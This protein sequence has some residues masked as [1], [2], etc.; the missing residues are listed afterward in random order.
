MLSRL[1][2]QDTLTT[3]SQ[4]ILCARLLTSSSNTLNSLGF[5]LGRS[6]QNVSSP[7]LELSISWV[8]LYYKFILGTL[9]VWKKINQKKD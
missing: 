7:L 6:E 4:T 9:K 2:G 5:Y 8:L 3:L 1:A